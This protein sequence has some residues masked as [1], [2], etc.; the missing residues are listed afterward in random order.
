MKWNIIMLFFVIY[1]IHFSFSITYS[2][3]M[4]LQFSV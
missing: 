3:F 1:Y 2:Y 4:Y